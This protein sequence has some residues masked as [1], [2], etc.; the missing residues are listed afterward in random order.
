MGG[1]VVVGCIAPGA[2]P[3]VDPGMTAGVASGAAAGVLGA[4]FMASDAGAAAVGAIDETGVDDT[5]PPVEPAR[6]TICARFDGEA[7]R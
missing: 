3:G 5:E 2:G 4:G 6:A 1:I 7:L